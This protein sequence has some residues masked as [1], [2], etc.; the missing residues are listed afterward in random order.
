MASRSPLPS[1]SP[2]VPSFS[3]LAPVRAQRRCRCRLRP[4]W[5]RCRSRRPP[6][7]API[8]RRCSRGWRCCRPAPG[9]SAAGR[10]VVSRAIGVLQTYVPVDAGVSTRNRLH[11]LRPRR[12]SP[13]RPRRRC[14]AADARWPVDL[15][16]GRP[17]AGR[18]LAAAAAPHSVGRLV[19]HRYR[20][21]RRRRAG[22]AVADAGPAGRLGGRAGNR[23]GA[24]TKGPGAQAAETGRLARRV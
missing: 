11:P 13:A 10:A 21:R 6:T 5:G 23:P 3:A 17:A 20:R 19:S 9:T 14:G 7:S 18:D 12:L 1:R 2:R 15:Q 22:P 4:G 16:V 8:R 24:L